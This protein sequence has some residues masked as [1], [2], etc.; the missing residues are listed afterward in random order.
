MPALASPTLSSRP[1]SASSSR[2][3]R[4]SRR[5]ISSRQDAAAH[6]FVVAQKRHR[7]PLTPA[8]ATA[9]IQITPSL[10][11]PLKLV[12]PAWLEE[13]DGVV[14]GSVYT[15]LDGV[16]AQY[17]RENL[18]LDDL[19]EAVNIAHKTLRKTYQDLPTELKYYMY[20]A[21]AVNRPTHVFAVHSS[22]AS[23]EGESEQCRV[24]LFPIHDL[25]FYANCAY[26][27][28]LPVHP[29]ATPQST[30][31]W[32]TAIPVIPLRMPSLETFHILRTF[33]YTQQ[34]ESVL[35][36]LAPPCVPDLPLLVQ[37]AR[38]IYG[39]WRNACELGVV[40]QR[41]YDA[42]Q[43]SWER[44]IFVMRACS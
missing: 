34:P 26:L 39:L 1:T 5:S 23:S 18:P 31:P 16:P 7:R 19:L 21:I 25:V 35:D 41:L 3:S 28:T 14:L 11:L 38:K 24:D 8:D 15:D 37:H 36:A 13:V 12:R 20:D 22:E 43:D 33:L 17:I 29:G 27:T 44:T 40:D 2:S 9:N 32:F 30:S 6:S 4:S 10:T 42:I